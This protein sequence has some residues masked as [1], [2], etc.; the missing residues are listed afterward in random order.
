MLQ[1]LTGTF[2]ETDISVISSENI[3]C[4][5]IR[6]NLTRRCF[7]KNPVK[8]MEKSASSTHT[9]GTM[10]QVAT[11]VAHDPEALIVAN[12]STMQGEGGHNFTVTIDFAKPE[13]RGNESF[14]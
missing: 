2:Q 9:F 14:P 8:L 12:V 5:L 3:T 6:T 11:R 10:F 1:P 4:N 13:N 7:Y